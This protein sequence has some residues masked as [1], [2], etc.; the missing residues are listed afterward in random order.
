MK[1]PRPRIL[2]D[3]REQMPWRF[4]ESVDVETVTL[5]TGDYSIAGCTDLVRIERKSLPDLVACV[6]PSRERFEDELRRLEAFPVRALIVEAS[7]E[8]IAAHAYRSETRPASV[9]GSLV[10]WQVDRR[11][12]VVLAGDW[13]SAALVAEKILTRVFRK[14]MEAA[15]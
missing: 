13:E 8:A 2:I 1:R 14:Q 10:A 3:T 12:P 11:L 5:D 9:I 7:L 6:G 4:S 15:A